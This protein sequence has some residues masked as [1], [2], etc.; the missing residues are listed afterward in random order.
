[1][2]TRSA[3][4]RPIMAAHWA[5]IFTTPMSTKSTTNGS[6]AKIEDRPSES[7]TGSKTWVY[8]GLTPLPAVRGPTDRLPGDYGMM[9]C[10]GPSSLIH[11]TRARVADLPVHHVLQRHAVPA[12]RT[13]GGRGAR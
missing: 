11:P 1:M 13:G 3:T 8:I 4:A 7:L 10:P 2:A 5:A 6:A 12:D 9:F